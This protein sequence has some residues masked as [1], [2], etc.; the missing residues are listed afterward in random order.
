MDAQGELPLPNFKK[1]SKKFCFSNL[2][3]HVSECHE[4][5][6]NP[7]DEDYLF[8]NCLNITN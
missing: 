8:H 5:N 6:N 2:D 3:I 4:L 7:R 1:S